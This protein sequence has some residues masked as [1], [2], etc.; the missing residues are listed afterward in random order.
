MAIQNR[1]F[2]SV[3]LRELLKVDYAQFNYLNDI[4]LA[5]KKYRPTQEDVFSKLMKISLTY[6]HWSLRKW[7]IKIEKILGFLQKT[8]FFCKKFF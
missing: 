3:F 7:R 2:F 1:D 8:Y 6:D 4:K 5:H